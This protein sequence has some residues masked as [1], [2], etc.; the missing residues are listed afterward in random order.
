MTKLKRTFPLFWK[1]VSILLMFVGLSPF[2]QS[3][4]IEV[5]SKNESIS[6]ITQSLE[7]STSD[8]VRYHLEKEL[9]Y[10]YI[11]DDADKALES[12][13]KSLQ[14]A[15]IANLKREVAD[16]YLDVGKAFV[17]KEEFE[18]A[19]N[20]FSLAIQYL[21]DN[22]MSANSTLARFNI[23]VTYLELHLFESA[24]DLLNSTESEFISD[25]DKSLATYELTR[26]SLLEGDT[27]LAKQYLSKFESYIPINVGQINTDYLFHYAVLSELYVNMGYPEK[28]IKILDQSLPYLQI[29]NR[30]Y[31]NGIA[32]LTLA[33]IARTN[34]NSARA[35]EYANTA[36]SMF[37][38]QQ[39]NFYTSKTLLLLSKLYSNTQDFELGYDYL[40]RYNIKRDTFLNARQSAV[41]SRLIDQID[42]TRFVESRLEESERILSQGK[43]FVFILGF[44]LLCVGVLA[45][46]AFRTS[47]EKA[48]FAD[49][50]EKINADK[51]H[52]IGVVSHDLRSPLNSVMALS[53]IMIGDPE[54]TSIAEIQEFS[55]IILNS[56]YRMEH[57]IN[58]MLDAN[59]IETGN[60]KL[61]L[62][63]ISINNAISDIVDSIVY[64]GNEKEI[65]TELSIDND[66]PNI[67]ADYNAVQRVI[68]NLISNAYKFSPKHKTVKISASQ[69]GSQV[70][71]SIKDQGPGMSDIDKTKLFKKFE[72]LS[73]TPTGNEKSTGLGLFIVKN[74]MIEMNG[75]ILV[76][77]ELNKGTTFTVLFNI[78]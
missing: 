49:K 13:L 60:T 17:K 24:K 32:N 19:F 65:Q 38:L 39:E 1:G 20:N 43:Y 54:D 72:K 63:S 36:L 46:I 8:T 53:S 27:T 21:S 29:H 52:F 25:R 11:N 16:S 28:A 45:L 71:V 33:K 73:A 15:Q 47:K 50:I 10:I 40:R 26:L 2:I 74:L 70:Q 12:A 9:F 61:E 42:K 22:N 3:Q 62:K 68:E 69:K 67:L 5:E 41:Q 59:K 66:L 7:N 64:L 34:G 14:Y 6:R 57:L 31:Y 4:E 23:G 44:M 58:N 55:S 76:E 48:T 75:T 56:S 51:D 78:A 77:S 30:R 35:I 37:E 18:Q